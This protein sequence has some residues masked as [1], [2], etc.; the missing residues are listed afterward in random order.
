MKRLRYI[1]LVTLLLLIQCNLNYLPSDRMTS[2]MLTTNPDALVNVTNGNYAMF[3]DCLPFN[4]LVDLNNGYLR[5]YFQM[6][7]F[8]SD[9][10]VCG[11]VTT[12]P[13]YYSFTY[14]HSP[15]QQNVRYFWYV[16]YKIIN[17]ANTVIDAL[18]DQTEL[19]DLERQL[20]GENYF[21]RAFSM[22][23]LLKFFSWPY[24]V[25]DPN[26]NLGVIIRESTTDVG[27][28]PRATVAEC[29]DFIEKDLLKAA[30][31]MNQWRGVQYASK[32]AA[33]AFLSRFYLYKEDYQKSIAY[34]DS[35]INS[36]NF[37]LETEETFPDLYANAKSHSEPIWIIAFT[38]QDN[39]GKFGS[40]ASMY[41][42]DGNSGWGEEFAS[43]SLQELMAQ[44]REDIRWSMIDT[45]KN[46]DG[47]IATKNGIPVF[48]VLK[49]SFQDGDPNLSSPIMFR[50]AEMYL[51]K[52]EAYAKLGD[53][54]QAI[55]LVNFIRSHRGLENAL[56]DVNNLPAG[57]TALDVVLDERRIEFAFEGHRLTDLVRNQKPIIRDYWG[58]HLSGLR[59]SD[60]DLNHKPSEL[61][62][63]MTIIHIDYNDARVLYKIP[64]DEILA[65][66]QCLQN[67]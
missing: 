46:P 27:P 55:D 53:A 65:N 39:R 22:F 29:Y 7:D 15:D 58:Y 45:L 13:F 40:I 4:G 19:S 17:G 54:A 16:S 63:P 20:L 61:G 36:G 67:P 47:T 37:A 24:S 57:K 10:V 42:S 26:Q 41:Y 34:A 2:E 9:D 28:K 59:E 33:W 3:K 62:W 18:K 56:Y 23:N 49:F 44:H 31:L 32:Y 48:W 38:Q 64:V 6:S 60:I 52:A 50:L 35:V 21:L 8:A 12:D 25:G 11:S 1:L 43:P 30:N 51:N 66:P 14:T 5:Q